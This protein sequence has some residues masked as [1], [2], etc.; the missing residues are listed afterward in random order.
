MTDQGICQSSWAF[1]AAGA[2]D[3]QVFVMTGSLMETSV[4][5][6]LDCSFSFGN[7]GCHGGIPTWAY[8][9]IESA[10]GV[11]PSQNYPYLGYVSESYTL[12]LLYMKCYFLDLVLCREVLFQAFHLH[13]VWSCGE[14]KWGWPYGSCYWCWTN[15]VLLSPCTKGHYSVH[16]S[17]RT[18]LPFISVL[19]LMHSLWH[20]NTILE[21][22]MMTPPVVLTHLIMQCYWWAMEWM[23]RQDM[24]TG[25]WRTGY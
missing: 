19:L 7:R 15:K 1:S 2:T 21:E 24:I 3:G 20:S 9:Y 17:L 12:L 4:Q 23:Q 5:Q 10:A 11:C 25:C 13:W 8:K 18:I 14:R 16:I 22:C 6:L